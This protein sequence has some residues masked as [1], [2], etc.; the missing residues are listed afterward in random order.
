[1]ILVFGQTGQL[2]RALSKDPRVHALDRSTA[3]LT[4]PEAC[5]AALTTHRTKAVII[6]AAYTQ[7]DSA[8]TDEDQATII[9]GHTPGALAKATAALDIPIV[10]I[11]TDYVFSG[12]GTRPW[13]PADPIAPLNAYGRSKAQG[14][15]AIAA[16]GGRWAILRTSWVISGTGRNFVTTMLRLGKDR[17]ELTV[18]AD[19]IGGPTPAGA[20]ATACLRVA[21]TLMDAPETSGLYHFAGSPDASWADLARATMAAG[22]R[23]CSIVDIPTT[24]YPTPATRPLNSRLDCSDIE[25]VF[26][27]ARPDWR[28][29]L[30]GIVKEAETPS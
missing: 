7:V 17:P 12:E 10:S 9:N 2:G 29:A 1:M 26:G 21:E 24:D 19:Q 3:D 5:V 8:E 18:V 16:A 4:N 23:S 27:I 13:C 22:N 15:A 6:A 30:P 20:L 14:E 28:A 25:N 11:S